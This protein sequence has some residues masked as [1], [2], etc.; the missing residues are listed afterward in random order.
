[1]RSLTWA[2]LKF[3]AIVANAMEGKANVCSVC[4]AYVCICAHIC[5]CPREYKK[6]KLP[7]TTS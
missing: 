3:L 4:Y 1:M 2:K 7:T 6:I 5:M